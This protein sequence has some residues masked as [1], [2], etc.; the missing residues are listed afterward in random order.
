MTATPSNIAYGSD[1]AGSEVA[2]RK[3]GEELEQAIREACVAE[4]GHH[5]YADLSIESVATRAQ[6]GKASIYRRWP[7]KLDL[8]MDAVTELCAGPLAFAQNAIVTDEMGSTREALFNLMTRITALMTGPKSDALRAV[9][10][11]AMRDDGL[12]ETVQSEFFEPRKAALL[13]LLQRGVDRGEVRPDV[14]VDFVH[15]VIG[16]ALSHRI[17]LRRQVPTPEDIN[18]FLDNFLMPAISPHS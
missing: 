1:N 11:A 3:R 7:T 17:L 6:T 4:L 16:G 10:S 18:S 12:A 5:G 2:R 15:D 9:W 8:V 14:P 13:L